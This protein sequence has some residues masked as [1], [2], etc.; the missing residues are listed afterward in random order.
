MDKNVFSVFPNTYI[1]L[2]PLECWKPKPGDKGWIIYSTDLSIE[3]KIAIQFLTFLS[4]LQFSTNLYVVYLNINK[5][6]FK[7]NYSIYANE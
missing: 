6:I 7:R 2:L 1:Y 3:I 4:A 5:L